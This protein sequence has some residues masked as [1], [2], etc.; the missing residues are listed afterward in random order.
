MDENL[1]YGEKIKPM[2]ADV[3]MLIKKLTQKKNQF[4][5][6]ALKELY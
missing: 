5:L 6:K 1:A 2:L 4:Y 3:S